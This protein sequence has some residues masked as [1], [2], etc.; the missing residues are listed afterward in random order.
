LHCTTIL[1]GKTETR[2]SFHLDGLGLADFIGANPERGAVVVGNG[3][4][5]SHS[6]PHPNDQEQ[7][8]LLPHSLGNGGLAA[9]AGA[10][11][12]AS[13]IQQVCYIT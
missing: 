8:P 5:L 3:G 9:F 11:T 12:P 10:G 4:M 2:P 6:V 1:F 13:M 7:H